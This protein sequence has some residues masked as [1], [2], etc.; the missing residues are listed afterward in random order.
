MAYLLTRSQ[1]RALLKAKSNLVPTDAMK[2]DFFNTPQGS[3]YISQTYSRETAENFIEKCTF[4]AKYHDDNFE[5]LDINCAMRCDTL[6]GKPMYF[7]T[8]DT[9][10][11]PL[12]IEGEEPNGELEMQLKRIQM[13]KRISRRSLEPKK[14]EIHLNH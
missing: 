4:D 1:V 7:I 10:Y 14:Q 13:F 2:V 9:S 3:I 8:N 5:F 11:N 6:L 12:H